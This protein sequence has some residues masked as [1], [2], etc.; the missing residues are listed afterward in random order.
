MEKKTRKWVFLYLRYGNF[1]GLFLEHKVEHKPLIF[2][3]CEFLVFDD[4]FVI[5]K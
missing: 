1:F 2:E 3:E 4:I 5:Y